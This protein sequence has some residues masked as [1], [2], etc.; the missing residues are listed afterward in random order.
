MEELTQTL[1]KKILPD[2][3]RRELKKG[4]TIYHSA[5]PC[6][7]SAKHP[8]GKWIAQV[9]RDDSKGK[10]V[11]YPVRG[12]GTPKEA[13]DYVI[14]LRPNERGQVAYVKPGE[15]TV[16]DL[17]EFARTHRQKRLTESTKAGK[18]S[19][20]RLYIEREWADMPLSKVT[21]RAAQE[22]VTRIETEIENGEAGTLGIGQLEKVRTDLHALFESLPAFS[23]DY[24]DRRNPFADLVFI[25]RPP[26]AKVTIES[27]HFAA[28]EYACERLKS[29]G[30]C[31]RWVTDCMLTSLFSGLRQG[32]TMAL[33]RDQIDFKNKAIVVD[34]ALR[35]QSRAIDPKTRLEVGPVLRQAMHLPKGGTMTTDKTRIVPISNQLLRILKRAVDQPRV[36]GAEWDLLWPGETGKLREMARFRAAW[37]T[38]RER[39][40]ELAT[41][42]PLDHEEGAPWPE[43]PKKRGWE[44]NPLVE[45]ARKNKSLRLPD[46]FG[47]IDYRDTRN[48]F[49]SY[50]NE[51]GLSQAS[52]EAFLGHSGGLTNTV[53]TS[54]TDRAF[55]K[56]QRQLSLGWKSWVD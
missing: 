56:A 40:D 50:M 47:D 38:L 5:L 17:Y 13:L 27:H 33:C 11:K 22:W 10:L 52:R 20:W 7:V 29:A 6:H 31:T 55:R 35:R 49:A 1:P 21:R 8:E 32:E 4:E 42:A 28:I 30:L 19:R 45:A 24:E 48:S 25:P 3:I 15:P 26:R 37:A 44:K 46:I 43:A 23:P 54:V 39:L 41:L 51:V 12:F 2:R 53:Y 18:E 36:A 34:R 9:R 16:A 14:S